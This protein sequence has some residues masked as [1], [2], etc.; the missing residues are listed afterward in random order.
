MTDMLPIHRLEQYTLRFPEE[1]LL[2][3][4]VVDAEEDYVVVFRGFSSSL[5]RPTAFD[6]E[7]P[8]LP[9]DAVIE[10]IDRLRGPYTPDN[11]QYLEQ[12]IPWITFSDRLAK[13]GL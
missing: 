5:A 4:A 9:A 7:I 3:S 2:V 11:P 6:P 10:V 8:V 12:G 13:M 1:V